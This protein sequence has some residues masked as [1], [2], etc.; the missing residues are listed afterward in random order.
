MCHQ[1]RRGEREM[2]GQ[3]EISFR[4]AF[5]IRSH[6]SKTVPVGLVPTASVI[7]RLHE[8]SSAMV[9]FWLPCQCHG[10]VRKTVSA[11]HSWA[12]DLAPC[13]GPGCIVRL[14]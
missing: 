13:R 2:M 6:G 5:R 4:V 1:D 7:G 11:R 12:K 3:N 8:A 10:H 9:A 14:D